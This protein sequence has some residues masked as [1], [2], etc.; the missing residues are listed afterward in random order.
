MDRFRQPTVP[1]VGRPVGPAGAAAARK[2]R[3]SLEWGRAPVPAAGR[4]APAGS[5]QAAK[6]PDIE[7]SSSISVSSGL[8]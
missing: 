6:L 4:A 5:R 7:P 8:V 3:K 2:V 1:A